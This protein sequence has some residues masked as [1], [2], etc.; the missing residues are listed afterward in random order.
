[1]NINFNG[2]VYKQDSLQL[3]ITD[4]GFQYGDG[5]FETMIWKNDQ[6][7][8]LSDHLNRLRRGMKAL[9]LD[10]G[11][12][13]GR[14]KLKDA[15]SGLIS[16][17]QIYGNARIKMIVWRTGNGLFAPESHSCNYLITASPLSRNSNPEK[18]LV[19]ICKDVRLQ[20]SPVS[21]FKTLSSLP[22]ILAGIEKNERNLDDAILLDNRNNLSECLYSN[23]FWIKGDTFYTP[24]LS[25]ACVEGIRRKFIIHRLLTHKINVCEVEAPVEDLL[26]ADGVFNC[27]VTG[28]Y[29]ILQVENTRYSTARVHEIS[30]RYSLAN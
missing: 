29:P 25:T 5:L 24:A 27:N 15:I 19:A 20:R 23:L 12:I 28:I 9:R 22:Y 30:K 10:P 1:M 14:E 26:Q 11:N 2:E 8:F 13:T 17:N 6:V 7:R 4:R 21:A 3:P 18:K 16:E